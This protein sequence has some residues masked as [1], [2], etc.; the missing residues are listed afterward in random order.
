MGLNQ[1]AVGVNK[2]LSLINLHLITGQ[3]G[4]PGSGPFSL[5][6]QPNAMG[7]REAGGLANLLPAHR[8]LA[9]PAERAFVQAFWGGSP[10]SATPGYTATEMFDAL[11]DGRLKAIW[12]IGTNP[13]VSLPDSRR[14]EEALKRA[15]FVVVQDIS[16]KPETLPYADVVLPAAAW[17]EKEGT[18]TNAERRIAHLGKVAEAPEKPFR[19]PG[20]SVCSPKK[21][22]TPGLI[23]QIP[24]TSSGNTAA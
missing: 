8:D 1:S 15:R 14:A 11:Y 3:I 18:M 24:P 16:N 22:A 19:M 5:T 2:N 13:L 21:W 23:T 20:S 7:G 4:K 6:G 17:A 10:I 12:I 9:D